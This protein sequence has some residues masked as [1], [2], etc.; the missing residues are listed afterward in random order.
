MQIFLNDKVEKK[1]GNIFSYKS[2]IL[3][4][5][6]IEIQIKG[7]KGIRKEKVELV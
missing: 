2:Y 5:G 4:C 7:K 3:S 6:K 1:M